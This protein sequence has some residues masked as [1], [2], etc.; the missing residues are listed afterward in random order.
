MQTAIIVSKKDPAGMNIK[1]C[2]LDLF[3]FKE[4][5]KKFEKNP[6][7][8]LKNIT[9]YTVNKE[10]IYCE[11]I[12]KRI[13]KSPGG[14]GRGMAGR[15]IQSPDLIIFATKHEAEAKIHSLSVHAPGNWS[16]A[17]FGGRDNQLCIAPAC[18]LKHALLVLERLAKN[19]DFEI[20]QEVTH[21]GPYLET[22]C[23]FIEIG[24]DLKSWQDRQAGH[25]IA[26]TIMHIL[27][28]RPLKY[29]AALGIGGT[30]Y[31]PTFKKIIFKTDYALGHICP[32]YRLEK[33]TK[34]M[35]EQAIEKT[36]ERVDLVILDWK[37]L[38]Q[39]KEKIVNS[40][41]ELKIKTKKAKEIY[42]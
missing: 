1:E 35:I 8:Q 18:Y 19:M 6:V 15:Q 38:G 28:N 7:Y 16:S 42:K 10:T 4:L 26:K 23:M 32:K 30:H 36:K 31:T 29:K 22:P 12:D 13:S 41:D 5:D 34:E 21:H 33:L 11:D 39:F 40:L 9:L 24:S 17:K 2:L 20:V 27:E 37:G 25:I 3:P 14:N